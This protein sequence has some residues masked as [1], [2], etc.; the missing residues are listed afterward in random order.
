MAEKFFVERTDGAVVGE[1]RTD[2]RPLGALGAEHRLNDGA[3]PGGRN[4]FGAFETDVDHRILM[5]SSRS[6]FSATG[7][8]ASVM[9]STAFWFL[10]NATTS[11]IDSRPRAIVMR[12]SRPNARP[13]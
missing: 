9:G 8:G 13:P 4:V 7:E 11:R 6:C 2:G 10:G 3:D 5:C 12:R 1:K